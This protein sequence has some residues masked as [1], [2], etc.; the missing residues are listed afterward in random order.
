V[1]AG[2]HTIEV[3]KDDEKQIASKI[4]NVPANERVMRLGI[5]E[6]KEAL[7]WVQTAIIIMTILV[8]VALVIIYF[9]NSLLKLLQRLVG[10]A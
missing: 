9:R 3:K 2:V 5:Q 8:M 10:K 6:Q 1:P 4:V 7:N